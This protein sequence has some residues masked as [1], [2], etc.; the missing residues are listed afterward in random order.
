MI[1]VT[2]HEIQRDV[3][4]YLQR[5]QAGETIIVVEA[6]QLPIEIKPTLVTRTRRLHESSLSGDINLFYDEE[7]DE[8]IDG[9]FYRWYD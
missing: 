8:E 9:G 5:V 7:S 2:L 3:A 6:G 4:G 1:T